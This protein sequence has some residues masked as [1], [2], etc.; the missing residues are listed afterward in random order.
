MCLPAVMLYRTAGV[1]LRQP[2]GTLMSTEGEEKQV[3]Y[4][5][6]DG[7][8]GGTG[9][10]AMYLMR[11]EM[12]NI[13][14]AIIR[15]SIHPVCNY[16]WK[17]KADCWKLQVRFTSP[18]QPFA[19]LV[20]SSS[21]EGSR[22]TATACFSRSPGEVVVRMGPSGRA[23]GRATQALVAGYGSPTTCTIDIN[24]FTED[25][26]LVIFQPDNPTLA[27]VL[28]QVCTR[29]PIEWNS[30]AVQPTLNCINDAIGMSDKISTVH[31]AEAECRMDVCFPLQSSDVSPFGLQVG[32]QSCVACQY[33][34]PY[35]DESSSASESTP[36]I[37]S[38][39]QLS[40]QFGT[41]NEA[42]TQQGDTDDRCIIVKILP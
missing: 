2:D 19:Q 25:D 8:I 5:Q 22:C 32:W 16:V 24:H 27:P 35:T 18:W 41:T 42:G 34:S 29:P 36:E 33:Q 7:T 6:Q 3:L 38:D 1:A 10:V 30:E 17:L 26:L 23:V 11:H 20:W 9:Q 21:P 4:I 31:T 40:A 12:I 14:S 13:R 15:F 28:S 39:D 37:C